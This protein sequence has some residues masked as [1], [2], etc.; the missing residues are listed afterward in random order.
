MSDWVRIWVAPEDLLV[1]VDVTGKLPLEGVERVGDHE[2]RDPL[3]DLSPP[4]RLHAGHVGGH[5]EVDE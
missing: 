3:V 1:A 2:L 5:T 4:L